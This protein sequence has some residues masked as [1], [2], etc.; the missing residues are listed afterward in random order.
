VQVYADYCHEVLGRANVLVVKYEHMVRDFP[1]WL[2][3][4]LQ[5][6]GL[7]KRTR[8]VAWLLRKADFT[9]SR[10]DPNSHKRQVQPGDHRR[11]LKPE[12]IRLLDEIFAD[13]LDALDYPRSSGQPTMREG[14]MLASHERARACPNSY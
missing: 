1:A 3:Q 12:T 5:F 8:T 13:V 11:K 14:R 4:I 6:W 2:D 9:V 7:P 10:E